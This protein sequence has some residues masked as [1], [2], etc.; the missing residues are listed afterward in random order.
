MF[1]LTRPG[2]KRVEKVLLASRSA[3]PTFDHTGATRSTSPVAG[4]RFDTYSGVVGHGTP[5]WSAACDGLRV[6]AAHSGAGVSVT[7]V[8]GRLTEGDTVI[9]STRVGPLHVVI[10]CRIVYVVV[11]PDRYGFAY[12]TLPGHPECGEEAFML[13]RSDDDVVFTVS[14]HSRHAE[15][16][17]K[18]GA[19]V[20]RVVQRRTNNAYVAGLRAYVERAR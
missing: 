19:P 9:A 18:L 16:L 12:A 5:D 3:K 2:Q 8:S 15:L 17:A 14:A 1:L 10:P 6:W 4:F 7:P 13:S 11:E 20:S